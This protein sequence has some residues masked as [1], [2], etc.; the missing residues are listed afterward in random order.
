MTGFDDDVER[1]RPPAS[2][3][4]HVERPPGVDAVLDDVVDERGPASIDGRVAALYGR[5]VDERGEWFF[6]LPFSK[7]TDVR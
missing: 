6:Y 4:G 7:R 3:D 1:P 5:S 2:I